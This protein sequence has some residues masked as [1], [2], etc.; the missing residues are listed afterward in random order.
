MDKKNLPDNASGQKY[1]EPDVPVEDAWDNMKQLLQLAPA[2]AAS[3]SGFSFGKGIGRWLAGTGVVIIAAVITYVVAIKKEKPAPT[4]TQYTSDAK[5]GADT[6]KDTTIAYPATQRSKTVSHE[7]SNT[8]FKE[9]ALFLEKAYGITIV[10]KNDA[11]NNC[12]VTTRFDN[13]SLEEI[14]DILGYTL[15][16][17]YKIDEKKNQVIISGDGCN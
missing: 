17:K 2:A 1:P 6:I 8:P 12:M 4:Q 13:K 10:V 14:L 3:P 5:P 9:V 7:F 11:I 15:A 16:F